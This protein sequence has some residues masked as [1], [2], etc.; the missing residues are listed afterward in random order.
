MRNRII[1]TILISSVVGFIIGF[2]NKRINLL[3][4]ELRSTQREL[5]NTYKIDCE[6][7][8]NEI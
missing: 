1:F 3:E 6:L 5:K 2:Y 8:K 7:I 4:E